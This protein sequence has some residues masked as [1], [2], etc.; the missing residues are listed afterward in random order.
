M[1]ELTTKLARVRAALG[2]GDLGG[3]R[4]RGIEWFAWATCGGS[5]AVL[6]TTDLGV[7]EVLVTRDEA[8]VLTDAIE[9]ERLAAEE[10]PADLP[11]HVSPW[12]DPAVREAFVREACEGREVASDRPV[13]AEV[14]LPAALARAPLLPEEVARYRALG[15]EAAAAMTDLAL[16]V[17]PDW[18]GVRLAGEASAL[19]WNRGMH[20]ALVLVGDERRLPR[21]RHPTPSRDPIGE[22]VMIVFCARRHGLFANFTRF[23]Y[24]R[25]PT[26]AER[27]LDAD[28]AAV[29]A[30]ALSESRPGATLGGV[31]AAIARAYA[32]SGHPGAERL[33]HQ[34]G[35]CGYLSRD[36]V[37]RPGTAA[38]IAEQSAVAWNPSLPGAKIEDTV[39]VG[40]AGLEILTVDPR[41]PT[42]D[43]AGRR[44]PA[45][46]VR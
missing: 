18:T 10:L 11:L 9:G 23:V 33:H 45:L 4:L 43:V 13:G 21:Y 31:L 3:V 28:V 6:L 2:A 14:A 35:S 30:V 26:A 16:A 27:A 41:W 42:D 20:P 34:G 7:A 38:R 22:R 12:E 36:V 40:E 32:A 8:W 39:L 44:R 1:P 46:L 5:S 17:K 29:E 37:A 19:L 24:F 25:P 15:A